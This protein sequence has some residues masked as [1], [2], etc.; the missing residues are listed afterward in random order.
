MIALGCLFNA[1]VAGFAALVAHRRAGALVAW[2]SASF[3]GTSSVRMLCS[4]MVSCMIHAPWYPGR[5]LFV[6]RYV[7]ETRAAAEVIGCRMRP[8][9]PSH[10][11]IQIHDDHSNTVA[12]HQWRA[13]RGN[14]CARE[15]K[16]I[17][18]V[19]SLHGFPMDPVRR[20]RGAVAAAAKRFCLGGGLSRSAVGFPGPHRRQ[21]S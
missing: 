18:Y 16:S 4:T 17:R 14:G 19:T 21:P 2:V 7:P 6:I 20:L 3:K 8:M 10:R 12:F 1:K 11:V 15:R 9:A 13:C 5:V